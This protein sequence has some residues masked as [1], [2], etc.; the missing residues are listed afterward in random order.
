MKEVIDS[1]VLQLIRDENGSLTFRMQNHQDNPPLTLLSS[2]TIRVFVTGDLAYFAVILG[3]VNMA[4]G[5]C[6]WC[7]LSPKEW[8]PPDHDKGELWTLVAMAEVRM[9][10]SL[11]VTLDTLA[12]CRGCVNVP[13]RMCMPINAY[14]IPILHTEIGIGNRLLKLFLDW[15]DLRI[16]KSSRKRD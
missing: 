15:V 6:T 10:I 12:N 1:G 11:G 5:W 14:I 13:L 3:K 16:E 9:S 2:L 4:G 8:S 7:G